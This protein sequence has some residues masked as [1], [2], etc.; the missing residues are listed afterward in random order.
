MASHV[1]SLNTQGLGLAHGRCLRDDEV[2]G[3]AE[4]KGDFY[5]WNSFL[6]RSTEFD[7]VYRMPPGSNN[8][9]P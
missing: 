5:A 4:V 7:L 2:P 9:K 3:G 1:C 6:I 8:G